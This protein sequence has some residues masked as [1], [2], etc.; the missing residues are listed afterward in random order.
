MV[1]LKVTGDGSGDFC[2]YVFSTVASDP[3]S[4]IS[5]MLINIS[6][7]M[8]INV[9]RLFC[10]HQVYVEL[11]VVSHLSAA[12]ASQA[13]SRSVLERKNNTTQLLLLGG[14]HFG[15]IDRQNWQCFLLYDQH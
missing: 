4:E 12:E 13:V 2:S 3:M 6:L 5:P 1:I 7:Q 8:V 11:M 9:C 15:F 14:L 10:I